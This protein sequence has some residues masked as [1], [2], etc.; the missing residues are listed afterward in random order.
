MPA[1]TVG[2]E[3]AC[4]VPIAASIYFTKELGYR[5]RPKSMQLI[6][7]GFRGVA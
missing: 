6:L 4:E 5:R 7:N 2:V 3:P 1:E